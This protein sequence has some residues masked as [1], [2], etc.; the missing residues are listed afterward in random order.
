MEVIWLKNAIADLRNI[1][2][3]YEARNPKVARELGQHLIDAANRLEQQ[4][5][6]A[7]KWPNSDAH[8]LVITRY[9]YIIT[10]RIRG[11]KVLVTWIDHSAQE[12]RRQQRREGGE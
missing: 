5:Y 12:G 2:D 11:D 7:P 9:P 3:Y 6:N 8:K 4:P 1:Q 10:Y